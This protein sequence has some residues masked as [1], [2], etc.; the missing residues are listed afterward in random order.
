MLFSVDKVGSTREHGAAQLAEI[1]GLALF[2]LILWAAM[3]GA[4]YALFRPAEQNDPSLR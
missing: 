1:A 4:L 2:R 3:I